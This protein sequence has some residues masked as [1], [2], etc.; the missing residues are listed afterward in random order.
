MKT[1]V[2]IRHAKAESGG[3]DDDFNRKLLQQ[4][5]DDAERLSV[6]L[7]E[8]GFNPQRII[9]SSAVRAKETAAIYANNL[10][11]HSPIEHWD[12]FYHSATTQELLD[13]V[14]ETGD[15]KDC[16]FIFGH[17]PTMHYLI[18][19]ICADFNRDT[20]TCATAIIQFSVEKWSE[21]EARTGKLF[22]HLVP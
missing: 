11:F 14:A 12:S 20:P 10:S 15:D 13:K 17:N 1:L 8:I 2:M 7:R 19:N 9:S 5:K 18:Y 16:V 22:L 3:F 4:G 21:I 6:K